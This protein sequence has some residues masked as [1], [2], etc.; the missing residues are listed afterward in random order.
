M[1]YG[2]GVDEKVSEDRRGSKWVTRTIIPLIVP[3][4]TFIPVNLV[5]ELSKDAFVNDGKV[6]GT[7]GGSDGRVPEAALFSLIG[8]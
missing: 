2:R 5:F 8:K 1:K 4:G 6:V 3:Q 7:T